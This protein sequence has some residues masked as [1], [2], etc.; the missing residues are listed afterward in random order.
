MQRS[1]HTVEPPAAQSTFSL[2]LDLGQ[3]CSLQGCETKP[4][5]K[6]RAAVPLSEAPTSAGPHRL[7]RTNEHVYNLIPQM[8]LVFGLFPS[9]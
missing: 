7:H 3:M 2:T 6:S 5:W 9:G 4:V 1:A 8:L